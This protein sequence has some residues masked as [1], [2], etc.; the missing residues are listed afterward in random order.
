MTKVAVVQRPSPFLDR[1][2][3]FGVAER[4]ILEAKAE[5]ADLVVLPEAFVGGYPEWIWRIEPRDFAL[6]AQI[7]ERLHAASVDLAKNELAPLCDAA[8]RAGVTVVCGIHE[9]DGTSGGGTL[10]NT[11][12][13]VGPDGA[14][15]NRHRKLVPTNPERMVWGPGDASGLRAI[16]TPAGRLGTLI[17]WESYMPLARFALYAQGIEI[18]V[19]PT[20]DHGE[21]WITAMKHI[22]REARCFVIGN[23]ICMQAKDVPASFPERARLYADGEEWLNPGDSIVVDPTGKA[24]AGPMQKERGILYA[25]CDLARVAPSRRALDVAGHYNRPDVFHFEVDRS[26]AK[27]AHFT[28]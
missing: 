14:L 11:V 7:H 5:G 13:V 3:S 25:T 10:Y 16:D 1:A 9:R 6:N 8:K 24:I 17:C 26:P 28:R 22:A 19:A 18:Y 21:S 23:A 2:A 12:V 4:S 27:P 15:L 20:W